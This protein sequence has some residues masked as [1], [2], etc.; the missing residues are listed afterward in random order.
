LI[1]LP[2]CVATATWAY[3]T[4]SGAFD[5]IASGAHG[6]VNCLDHSC[7]TARPLSPDDHTARQHPPRTYLIT[8]TQR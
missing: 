4:D 5:L 3:I 2:V 8:T 6:S 1:N 7:T